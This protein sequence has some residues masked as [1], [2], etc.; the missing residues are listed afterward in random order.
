MSHNNRNE[1]VKR[2][3]PENK[4]ELTRVA[5]HSKNKLGTKEKISPVAKRL[6]RTKSQRSIFTPP[7]DVMHSGKL[8]ITM[9]LIFSRSQLFFDRLLEDRASNEEVLL[10]RNSSSFLVKSPSKKHS[11][12]K[13]KRSSQNVS[14]CYMEPL[15]AK[16][17]KK[18][19]SCSSSMRNKDFA[20]VVPKDF[21]LNSSIL[22]T[23]TTELLHATSEIYLLAIMHA[24]LNLSNYSK[25]SVQ[26]SKIS[27][28][29]AQILQ[30]NKS[31]A[32][33]VWF[34]MSIFEKL[35]VET[36][37]DKSH[38]LQKLSAKLETIVR[39][40]MKE[41]RGVI[42]VQIVALK[43]IWVIADQKLGYLKFETGTLKR[44]VVAMT[45]YPSSS[46]MQY[47]CC[48]LIQK[49]AVDNSNEES[50]GKIGGITHVLNAALSPALDV[51]TI[52]VACAALRNLSFNDRNKELMVHKG[53]HNK[54]VA[55]IKKFSGTKS[56]T[57]RPD[58][59][60]KATGIIWNLADIKSNKEQLADDAIL[61]LIVKTMIKF[62]FDESIQE[63]SC[64]VLRAL[65]FDDPSR[66]KLMSIGAAEKILETMKDHVG[67]ADIQYQAFAVLKKLSCNDVNE[68]RLMKMEA[69]LRILEA[70]DAH[71]SVACIQERACGVLWNLAVNDGHK[72][73]LVEIGCAEKML[74]AMEKHIDNESVQFQTCRT[75][76][77]LARDTSNE[78]H[79]M[80]LGAAKHVLAAMKNHLGAH[81]IQE[82]GCGVLWNLSEQDEHKRELMRLGAAKQI[83]T[84]MERH[85]DEHTVQYEACGA[86]KRLAV[87]DVIEVEL[88][89]MKA[90]TYVLKAM[91]RHEKEADVQG[92]ACGVLWNLAFNG[93][94]QLMEL[95]AAEQILRAMNKH[96]T[97]ESVQEKACGTL[98]KLAEH[99]S[100]N[101]KLMKLNVIQK[102]LAAMDNH[103]KHSGVQYQA[104]GTLWNLAVKDINRKPLLIER[105]EDRVMNALRIHSEDANIVHSACG[106][107]S[108]LAQ[109][110]IS[111]EL[112]CHVA[113][114]S[115]G[116]IESYKLMDQ[117]NNS[118]GKRT[119][120]KDKVTT[121]S[122]RFLL[123]SKGAIST[124]AHSLKS[125]WRNIDIVSQSLLSFNH[126]AQDPKSIVFFFEEPT[127]LIE[128][129]RSAK[130]H[131][132]E[133][134]TQEHVIVLLNKIMQAVI[135]LSKDPELKLK[136]IYE[137]AVTETFLKTATSLALTLSE[138]NAASLIFQT[139]TSMFL[140]QIYILMSQKETYLQKE[141]L[142]R[143]EKPKRISKKNKRV[144]SENS[145]FYSKLSFFGHKKTSFYDYNLDQTANSDFGSELF[146]GV[147]V[148]NLITA[149]ARNLTA[150]NADEKSLL[151][152]LKFFKKMLK[153]IISYPSSEFYTKCKQQIFKTNS[154]IEKVCEIFLSEVRLSLHQTALW[155]LRF[156]GQLGNQEQIA[157]MER[158]DLTIILLDRLDSN[159]SIPNQFKVTALILI[160]FMIEKTN[161]R[162]GDKM[163]AKRLAKS[164]N[165]LL[166][167]STQGVLSNS[168][169]GHENVILSCL[170]L[171]LGNNSTAILTAKYFYSLNGIQLLE[172]IISNSST[173]EKNFMLANKALQVVVAYVDKKKVMENI[174]TDKNFTKLLTSVSKLNAEAMQ[175]NFGFVPNKTHL[176]STMKRNANSVNSPRP[177]NIRSTIRTPKK[178]LASNSRES[179]RYVELAFEFYRKV[180]EKNKTVCSMFLEEN[181][182]Y[183]QLKFLLSLKGADPISVK[184]FLLGRQLLKEV[185]QNS[186]EASLKKRDS[187]ESLA[188]SI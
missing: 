185:R 7:A 104:C 115:H 57:A 17:E 78:A 177:F 180:C 137:C 70:M 93:Q 171:F 37:G 163:I 15:R 27:D 126:L 49:L 19:S 129:V 54:V 50:L 32:K 71:L 31:N 157:F 51:E 26:L 39:D 152:C 184:Y 41:H 61:N 112:L 9:K 62:R 145:S 138:R 125:H 29:L 75:L 22:A 141:S 65:A 42:S 170:D 77:R 53:Y 87:D 173:E 143:A 140:Y 35:I 56:C 91:E 148:A 154:L 181:T 4:R 103:K 83:L 5:R 174:T 164:L 117:I 133:I 46:Q 47:A 80:R 132:G 120:I 20:L 105:A 23:M 160:R 116:R 63:Q 89:K 38:S 73:Q 167:V 166:L 40:S 144:D 84:S 36:Q 16:Q 124:I 34:G 69:G 86:L 11:S 13:K 109:T 96:Q 2:I 134:N 94:A 106:V 90:A 146:N 14:G 6:L 111:L 79:L 156:I 169:K 107:L 149:M 1:D 153:D 67:R 131:I 43:L 44:I 178:P 33:V 128:I 127:F 98:W 10:P 176:P 159:P 188:V 95:N 88:M 139:N 76:K 102:V 18:P 66:I 110:N 168:L 162:N 100:N 130:Y 135:V 58:I 113:P 123:S 24:L 165:A 183:I 92:Q 158:S 101:E 114:N 28:T 122:S 48:V 136:G 142:E 119:D 182:L 175:L 30:R 186:S 121:V 108:N 8:S 68:G 25:F 81:H 179:L 172:N 55:I 82:K 147:T 72:V 60:A 151:V 150:F 21:K 85:L 12:L 155:V 187:I 45:T 52:K 118:L 97:N 59:V 161:K 74:K 3:K 99:D 64:G